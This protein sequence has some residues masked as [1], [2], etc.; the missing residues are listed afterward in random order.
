MKNKIKD[1][2]DLTNQITEN[3]IREYFEIEDNE[4]IYFDWVT[5]GE[6]F[7]FA[8]YWFSFSTV[9]ECYRLNVSKEQL[10]SWYDKTLLQESNLSLSDFILSP[11]KRLKKEQEYLERL[12]NNCIFAEQEFK[13]ALEEYKRKKEIIAKNKRK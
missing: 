3:F 1:W 8:D 4:E 5:I 7:Q 9:L 12:K 13:K 10:F 6:V 2:R 11:E